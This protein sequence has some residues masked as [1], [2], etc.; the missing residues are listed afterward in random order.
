LH[1][2]VNALK[3]AETDGLEWSLDEAAAEEVERLAG[4]LTVADIGTLDRNH[5]DD[6][7]EDGRAEVSAG[8]ETD[9][10]DCT[11][12]TDVLG[13]LLEGFLV[14]GNED[15]GVRTE[16]VLG[17]GLYILDDVLAGHEVDEVA[18][19]ELLQAHSLLVITGVDGNGSEVRI[20]GC[21]K[22]SLLHEPTSNP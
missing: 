11:A 7:L 13:G 1:E 17:A 10:D 14:D 8:R 16:T 22:K 6:R 4:I 19:T 15:D 18:A 2:V 12:R 9:A 20:S 5:L 3:L 21:E